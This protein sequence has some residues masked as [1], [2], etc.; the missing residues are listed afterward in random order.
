MRIIVL[1]LAFITSCFS[2]TQNVKTYY[3]HVDKTTVKIKSVKD[4]TNF[5]EIETE[6]INQ[7]KFYGFVGLTKT[8]SS[9]D[10]TNYHYYYSY[11]NQFQTIV[12]ANNDS[13]VVVKHK[14]FESL[15]NTINKKL[16][17]LE[18]G[19][20]PFAKIVFTQEYEEQNKLYLN[21]IIDSGDFF[22]IDEIIIKCKNKVHEPTILSI[23]NLAAGE[24]YSEQKIINAQQQIK[25][26]GMYKMMR[27]VEIIFTPGK[28][29][30]YFYIEK[31]NA[32]NADGFVGFQQDKITS[33][34]VLNGYFNL[35]L[36]NAFNRAEIIEVNWKNNPNK[37]QNLKLNFE[38]PYL[39][40]TPIGFGT[41][42]NL[43]KQD[44]TFVRADSYFELGYTASFYKFGV[45]YQI[46]NSSTTIQIPNVLYRDY[47]KNTAGINLQLAPILNRKLKFYHPKIQSSFGFFKY[48]ADTLDNNFSNGKNIKYLVVY[49]HQIDL[50]KYFKLNN[51]IQFEGLLA[52]FNMTRNELIFFGGL[53]SI[54]GFYEL[55]LNGN[56]VAIINNEFEFKPVDVFSVKILYD[57]AQYHDNQ[58]NRAQAIGFGFGL[59]A[60]NY[61]LEII[62]ANGWINNNPFQVSNTKIHLGFVS[63]F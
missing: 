50:L 9:F 47:V 17:Q 37:T 54:R 11:T 30:L 59:N 3:F 40:K 10:K 28:A 63:K 48:N 5:N 39:F 12:L 21:Y 16:V 60:G 38:Y 19:G 35:A 55:E 44:S 53:K 24:P 18:N 43:F 46:E 14:N 32:S 29:K 49:K 45:F 61:A 2:F 4:T 33:K 36:R 42:V 56:Y 8:D 27:P 23:I 25:I 6:A 20:Y 62:L 41:K 52:E 58:F 51:G 7:L 13:T 31:E 22:I 57:Y 15:N 34:L 1:I 26:N